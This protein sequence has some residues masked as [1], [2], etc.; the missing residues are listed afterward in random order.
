MLASAREKGKLNSPRPDASRSQI[1]DPNNVFPTKQLSVS[2]SNF[3]SPSFASH[4][5]HNFDPR[6]P[7][8]NDWKA[9]PWT[10]IADIFA[11]KASRNE[12]WEAA[13]DEFFSAKLSSTPNAALSLPSLNTTPIHELADG[14]MVR[15]RCMIQDMFDP[16]FYVKAFKYK[17]LSTGQVG[18]ATAKFRDIVPLGPRQEVLEGSDDV[19]NGERQGLYCVSIPGEAPWVVEEFRKKDLSAADPVASSSALKKRM[20][21]NHEVDMEADNE[22]N[23]GNEGNDATADVEMSDQAEGNAPSE[24]KRV[25]TESQ[26][27]EVKAESP[28]KTADNALNLPIPHSK[29]KAAIVKVYG[30]ENFALNDCYEFVG[31]VS[32]DPSLAAFPTD[33]TEHDIIQQFGA[34]ERLA[35]SPPPSLVPRIHVVKHTKIGHG[36]PLLPE[37]LDLPEESKEGLLAEMRESRKVLKDLLTTAL[38]GDEFAAEYLICHLV[39]M[40]YIRST[41]EALTLGKF[42]LNLHGLPKAENYSK[43]LATLVQLLTCR[44][45]FLP[46]TVS[47]FNKTAF[48]PRKDYHANRLVSGLLQ[49]PKHT[50]LIL[51]ETAMSDGQLMPEGVKNLTAV[52]HL[53]NWQKL[54]YDFN[55]HQIEFYSDV[56]CLVLSEGRSML[57]SDAQVMLQPKTSQ[58]DVASDIADRFRTIG[59]GLSVS[60]LE[61]LRKYITLCRHMAFDVSDEV[62]DAVQKDFVES[63]Q[64]P[65]NRMTADDLHSML[66][67]SRLLSLSRAVGTMTAGVWNDVKEME[68]E[69]RRRVEHLPQRAR[70]NGPLA[71][72]GLA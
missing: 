53:I 39:S 28:V 47:T 61:R 25:K 58:S 67:L 9:A 30:D 15:F 55:Y 7:I 41:S 22:Q 40:I 1:L 46:M 51:D 64:N 4:V 5:V 52:G 24:T 60:V 6:M 32:L 50:H 21:R 14:Q 49:L 70:V 38:L 20:K 11:A 56:P 17:D 35:K 23:G 12:D 72:A 33:G 31:I 3:V 59:A 16:E 8:A 48:V 34:Q 27:G 66:V 37:Q 44:S 68:K 26:N 36:N 13:V 43:R 63:R 71:G 54:E 57:P 18:A 10:D 42:S 29:A 45:H 19:F 69:R 65:E 2:M 62:Q